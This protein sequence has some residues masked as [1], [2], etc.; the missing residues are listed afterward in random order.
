MTPRTIWGNSTSRDIRLTVRISSVVADLGPFGLL[1]SGKGRGSDY[2]VSGRP[3]PSMSPDFLTHYLA[4]GRVRRQLDRGIEHSLPAVMLEVGGME[5]VDP[6]VLEA[7][8]RVRDGLEGQPDR[9][10]RRKIR[11]AMDRERS[12]LGPLAAD[13]DLP[14][15]Q[16]LRVTASST[17]PP[18]VEES[19][20]PRNSPRQDERGRRSVACARRARVD[21]ELDGR[22]AV[23]GGYSIS[24]SC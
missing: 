15:D 4:I 21:G 1:G 13:H 10:I 14:T 22:E 12:R 20:S 7:A 6:D 8:C 5:L 2:Q 11:E 9:V 17:P 19:A 24:C 18:S 16:F 3:A 23:V